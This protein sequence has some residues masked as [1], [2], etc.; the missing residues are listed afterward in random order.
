MKGLE[1]VLPPM[2]R[3][4][5]AALDQVREDLEAGLRA[6]LYSRGTSPWGSWAFPTKE[7]KDRRRRVVVDY[8]LVNR[9]LVQFT[10]YIRRCSDV[11]A[12]L[13]GAAFLSGMDGARGFNQMANTS[14]AKEVLAVLDV[15]GCYLPEVLQLG[16]L[17][18]PFDFQFSTDELFTGSGAWTDGEL[19]FRYSGA[20]RA[21]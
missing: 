5:V 1:E 20:R 10:Y 14:R 13:A 16:P 11:K 18:G 17:S 12:S 15:S 3:N 9:H 8:R 7:S 4:A 21:V 6:G 2:D 19:R